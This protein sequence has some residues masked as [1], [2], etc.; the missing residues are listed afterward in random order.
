MGIETFP[1]PTKTINLLQA[2]TNLGSCLM[3]D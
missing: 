2:P 1:H 3:I